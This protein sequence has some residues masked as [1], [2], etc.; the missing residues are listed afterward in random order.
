MQTS[1]ICLQH[2]ALADSRAQSVSRG[3][4]S[5]TLNTKQVIM[6]ISLSRQS[7][8]LVIDDLATNIL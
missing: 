8:A 7:V 1:T 3:E 4:L 5:V 6:E 2:H